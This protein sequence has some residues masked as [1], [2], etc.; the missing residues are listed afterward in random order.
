[1]FAEEKDEKVDINMHSLSYTKTRY[2]TFLVKLLCT[3]FVKSDRG[4]NIN[5]LRAHVKT[6]AQFGMKGKNKNFFICYLQKVC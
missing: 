3:F 5:C 6:Y 4:T 1:M 2:L